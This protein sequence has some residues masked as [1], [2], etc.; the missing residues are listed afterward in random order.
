[1]G[2]ARE[3]GCNP[4]RP[5]VHPIPRRAINNI[6]ILD[7]I[8]LEINRQPIGKPGQIDFEIDNL[9]SL[10]RALLACPLIRSFSRSVL[11]VWTLFWQAPG[12]RD[13]RLNPSKCHRICNRG[14]LRQEIRLLN[15]NAINRY[16]DKRAILNYKIFFKY[17][18]TQYFGILCAFADNANLSFTSGREL[19]S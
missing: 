7:T 16:C 6:P 10:A 12:S 18:A 11:L 17:F 3:R 9:R 15:H 1:M 2:N 4:R 8:H 19:L 14:S 5:E 13:R